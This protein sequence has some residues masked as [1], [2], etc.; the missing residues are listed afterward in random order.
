MTPFADLITKLD[1]LI[2]LASEPRAGFY[3]ELRAVVED[4]ERLRS[5]IERIK[6]ER[7]QLFEWA[8]RSTMKHARDKEWIDGI[9]WDMEHPSKVGQDV[10]DSLAAHDRA[11]Q[12]KVTTEEP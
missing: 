5:E 9:L 4:R 6:E 10:L 7:A 8:A 3:R 11:A 2:V 1:R 12:A